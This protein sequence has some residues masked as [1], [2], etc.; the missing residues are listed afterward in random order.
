LTFL[1]FIVIFVLSEK[2]GTLKV[3]NIALEYKTNKNRGGTMKKFILA[4]LLIASFAFAAT[5]RGFDVRYERTKSDQIVLNFD[6]DKYSLVTVEKDGV[7]YSKIDHN[8]R[9]STSDKGYA[10]LP[11]FTATVQLKDD[12]NVDLKYSATDYAEYKLDYPLL[13]SRG[14]ISRSQDPSTI[15]YEIAPESVKDEWYPVNIAEN[16]DPFIMRDVRGTT[17]IVHPFQYNA[18][19]QI[20]RVYE[21]LTVTLTENNEIPSN[22]LVR[23]TNIIS[24]EMSGMYKTLF[25]NYNET[26]AM[27]VGEFGEI[28]LVYTP[29][30]GGLTALEPW[31]QWKEEMGY[32]VNLLEVANGRDLHANG[33]IQAAYDANPNILYVQLVGDW[34]NLK[35][36]FQNSVTATSGSQDPMLGCVVG[37]DQYIDIMVG[38]FSAD[39]STDVTTQINKAINYEKNPQ[40]GASWYDT[41]LGMARREGLGGGDDG[42]ADDEHQEYI[43]NRLLSFNYSNVERQYDDG[44]SGAT[45][46]VTVEA[47]P[48]SISAVINSGVSI[49][50]YINH[51]DVDLW[52]VGSSYYSSDVDALTNGSKLPFIISVACLVGQTSW[53]GGEVFAE[54]WLRNPNGGSVVGMFSSI[55]QPW[56]PPMCGQDYFNDILIGG[57]DYSSS[58]GSGIN[59]SEQRT[60]FG[61][62]ACNATNLM[63]QENPSDA[64]TKDTQEAWNIFGD[65]TLQVRTDTPLLIDNASTTI[66]M[67]SYSTTI[68]A[69]GSPV[70]GARV[71]LYKDGVNVTGTTDANGNITLNHSFT[72][73][74]NVTLTVTGYNLETEQ[75]VEIV[76]GDTGGTFAYTPSS[77][78][79]GNV[80]LGY[81]GIEQ[82]Q[83]SNSHSSE[84]MMGEITTISGYTVSLASKEFVESKDMKNILSYS[85]APQSSKTFNL[86]FEPT[87]AGTYN[88]NI[89]ITSSDAANP[90]NYIA[91]SG[92]GVSADISVP[93]S[94]SA[95]TAPGSSTMNNFSVSNNGEGTLDYNIS[96]N[97][98]DTKEFKGSG[99]PDAYGY[100]WKDSDEADGPVY[101]WIDITGVG[102]PV[103]LADDAVS[104]SFNLGFTFNFYGTDFTSVKI[105]SNGF[106]SFTTTASSYLNTAIPA[107]SEPY[108]LIALIWDD[109]NPSAAG[110]I[111]YYS[112]TAN[113]RFI[114]SYV[115]V[116]HYGTSDN[117]TVQAIIYKSGKIVYQY[118]SVGA[119]TVNSATV[120]IQN[121]TGTIG[122][123]VVY[124]AAY[125]KSNLAV[126]FQATTEWLTLDK[127]SGS[128]SGLSSDTITATYDATDLEAGI[129]TADLTVSSNDPDTPNVVIPVTFTVSDVPLDYPDIT[130][131]ASQMDTAA[132][133]EGT[134]T[135]S[136][137]IGNTGT[138][139]L[140]YT[141]S[142][143]YVVAKADI[144]V[145]SNDFASGLGS[146]TQDGVDIVWAGTGGQAVL[147][148]NAGGNP[149]GNA[150]ATLT[151]D[152]FDGT[153]CT[154]LTLTFDQS[155]T[156]AGES[157]ISVDYYD[158]TSWAQIY[159]STSTTTASQSL[160]LPNI[161]ANMQIRFTGTMKNRSGDSWTVDNIVVYGPE[162]GPGY[163]WLTINSS[164]SGTVV[165]AGSSTINLTCDA[166]GLTANTYNA[167]IT[168]D[169]D[170]PDEPS[171]VIPVVFVVSS[172][173]PPSAPENISVVTATSS[174]V[175]L[176]W[177]AVTGATIY[178]IYR[179]TTD[180]YSGFALYDSTSGTTYQD[181]NVSAGNKYFYYITSDNAK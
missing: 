58:P 7:T 61:S 20:L 56:I 123:Q 39:S 173:T 65:V 48:A 129:Y 83:I 113:E 137:N 71:T 11:R 181:T 49:I 143:E 107:T 117:N 90:T 19:K 156:T 41:A 93:S 35:S 85:V 44:P 12:K 80:S 125:L 148:A 178:H 54:H 111:Y 17:V 159:S 119:S 124:D 174:Q 136:F 6:V 108:N 105:C 138:A 42:E 169:S 51:G 86:T 149:N 158:G 5:A 164:L 110:N 100:K 161:S 25:I 46:Y 68:T 50:N 73:G 55:S 31:I 162:S 109:L 121:A 140:N 155:F 132:E 13:P 104:A 36:D 28:L 91:V 67:G 60:I 9:V 34:E 88:G 146:Y 141:I 179:S 84:Y 168:V 76:T 131:S 8:G 63:L 97:Y 118:Q 152:S 1:A 153:Q 18:E 15:P 145:H 81:S 96:I 66:L 130:V 172:T 120:G 144:T 116:P 103:S 171:V 77:L 114:V 43:R 14:V 176:S 89:T 102:T 135:D 79:Y 99:G 24:P 22:P 94:L 21:K 59:V 122:T 150:P 40:I 29:N 177:D 101:S 27:E 165:P 112:D 45:P 23:R 92:T 53:T 69:G 151:S 95:N 167:N 26:K 74:D 154:G 115:G 30:N 98:T 126:Q 87:A 139:D 64:A 38:R 78:S 37:T 70:E 2:L 180:P 57:Y 133:P 52:S 16:I 170:D 157:S 147:N 134:D 127:T 128:I 142:Q 33:D 47:T 62:L 75:S 32:K 175:D 10:A 72:T 3:T 166:A 4:V 160:T 106:L 163:S 82:F